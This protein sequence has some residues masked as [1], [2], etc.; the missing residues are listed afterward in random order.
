[1]ALNPNQ[2]FNGHNVIRSGVQAGSAYGED[3]ELG[4]GGEGA[5]DTN[6]RV[7]VTEEH[8]DILEAMGFA[9]QESEKVSGRYNSA[10]DGSSA[11]DH[12]I[13]FPLGPLV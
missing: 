4:A 6:D 11:F 10:A 3:E 5:D 13:G 2:K 7:V 12:G 9:R 8:M 1:V